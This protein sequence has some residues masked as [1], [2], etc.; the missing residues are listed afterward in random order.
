MKNIKSLIPIAAV[1]LLASC[2]NRQRINKEEVINYDI[3]T[4]F[5]GLTHENEILCGGYSEVREP[6]MDE[7]Q[8]FRE[9]TDTVKG[10]TFTPLSV[11][12]QVVAGTNY[13]FYCRFSDVTEE[14]NPGHC[15]LTIYK[16][17]PGKGEP[18]ITSI[19]K[20]KIL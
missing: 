5:A 13:K 14:F 9:V 19:E 17:L 7:Y 3:T 1:L 12:T 6:D 20:I 18:T 11:Q 15:Y 10:M 8:L 4:T 16:P 2:G